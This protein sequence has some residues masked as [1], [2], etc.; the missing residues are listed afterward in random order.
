MLRPV[1]TFLALVFVFGIA[2][3]RN[4][5]V[6]VADSA[7]HMPLP[8]ASVYDLYG[9][10]LGRS[11][12]H[13]VLPRLAAA[14]YPLTVRYIGYNDA[15]VTT[16]ATDTVFMGSYISE[17]PEMVVVSPRRRLLHILAYE[18]EYSTLTTYTDT[19]FLFREKMVDYMLSPDRKIKFRG[20][21][22]PRILSCR[23]YYRFTDSE[24]L[25]SVS[26]GS[27]QHFSWSDWMGIAPETP[28]PHALR[29][30]EAGTD[31][32]KGRYRP[33][34]IWRRAGDTVS[35][36]VNVLADDRARRWVPNLASFFRQDLDFEKFK[37]SFRYDNV[38]GDTV[39][40]FDLRYYS[41]DIESNGRGNNMFRRHRPDEPFYVTTHA[42]VY[43]LDREYITVKEARKWAARRFDT[44]EIGIFEPLDAPELTDGILAL[45][46]R[47]NTIDKGG[48]RLNSAP[49]MRLYS[50]LPRHNN[51]RFGRRLLILLKDLTG[52][53]AYK[54]HRNNENSWRAI[55]RSRPQPKPRRP[56]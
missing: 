35:V 56:D 34:E 29:R 19:V 42:D 53:T 4:R 27:V 50:D 16:A 23:S 21:M 45:I 46:D 41:F 47:V 24:G 6:V 44:D 7:T 3:G 12:R 17:L 10:A 32:L 14:S 33:I 11:D 2:A 51:F 39:S 37:V 13:G 31:T 49:D 38:V 52:I 15:T 22:T 1:I 55:R 8:N 54:T 36:S 26:D 43:V 28:M 20:W 48:V 9:K 5:G 25:D 18:R 30:L 40:P